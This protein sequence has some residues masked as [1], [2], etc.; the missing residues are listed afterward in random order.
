MLNLFL[1][2]IYKIGPT[3]IVVN[4]QILNMIKPSGHTA[5]KLS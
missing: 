4:G 1:E 2:I 5:L 3:F